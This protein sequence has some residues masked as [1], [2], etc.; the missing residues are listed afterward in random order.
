MDT[1]RTATT[2]S[3]GGATRRHAYPFNEL[4]H[5]HNNGTINNWDTWPEYLY[6]QFKGTDDLKTDSSHV[7]YWITEAFKNLIDA[8]DCDGFRV[9]AIK[10]VEFNWVVKWADDIRQYAT[11]KRQERLYSVWRIL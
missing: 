6:G 4:I 1:G 7:T 5:F 8:T 9:D 2:P 11:S 10:H 3:A